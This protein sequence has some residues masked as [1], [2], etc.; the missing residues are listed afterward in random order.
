MNRVTLCTM[1][2]LIGALPTAGLAQS[3]TAAQP[4]QDVSLDPAEAGIA[5]VNRAADLLKSQGP[6]AAIV[7]FTDALNQSRNWAVQRAIRFQL[8]D[9]YSQANRPDKALEVLKDQMASIP[10][11]P[12]PT[13][14]QLV[15]AESTGSGST[16]PQQ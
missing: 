8:A 6:D 13:L 10:P 12:A 14:L 15:P 11:S 2:L 5:A 3:S 9:L 16:T 7:Y 1:F 4:S